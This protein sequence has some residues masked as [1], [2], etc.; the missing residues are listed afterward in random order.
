MAH[1]QSLNKSVVH[2]FVKNYLFFSYNLCVLKCKCFNIYLL[3]LILRDLF[4]YNERQTNEVRSTYW[5]DFTEL[6]AKINNECEFGFRI[7]LLYI[8]NRKPSATFFQNHIAK[9]DKTLTSSCIS[10]SAGKLKNFILLYINKYLYT[11]MLV[12]VY[13]F[14]YEHIIFIVIWC[15]DKLRALWSCFAVM[16]GALGVLICV[17]SRWAISVI[18]SGLTKWKTTTKPNN[19]DNVRKNW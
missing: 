14:K 3:F 13:I 18:K 4:A 6:A 5:K 8:C 15:Q 7:C 11:H 10:T 1:G 2:L 17:V 12:W 19:V 9:E 16:Y